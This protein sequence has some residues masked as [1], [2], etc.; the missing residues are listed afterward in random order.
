M[1]NILLRECVNKYCD[2][3][4]ATGANFTKKCLFCFFNARKISVTNNFAERDLSL[5]LPIRTNVMFKQ[6]WEKIK[7]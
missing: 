3:K 2:R 4:Q 5:I 7:N 1:R 6:N